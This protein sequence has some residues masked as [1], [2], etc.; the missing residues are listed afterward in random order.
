MRVML[1]GRTRSCAA[2]SPDRLLAVAVERAEHRHL[3]HAQRVGGVTLGREPAAQSHH[4]EPVFRR[5]DRRRCGR[6]LSTVRVMIVSVT[7]YLVLTQGGLLRLRRPAPGPRREVRRPGRDADDAAVPAQRASAPRQRPADPGAAEHRRRLVH[8]GDRRL[9]GRARLDQQHVPQERR[10]VRQPHRGLRPRRAAGRVDRPVRR[11]RRAQG[12]PGRVGRRAQRVDPGPDRSTS[13][14]SSPAAASRRTSSAGRRR[15]VRRRA[16]HHRRSACSSTTRPGTPARR[17]SRRAAPAPATGWTDVPTSY[18]PAQEMRLRVLDSGVDKYGLNAYI[19]DS[20]DDG[21]HQL[22]PGAVLADQGR[23]RRRRRPAPGRVGRRQGHDRRRRA[24]RQDRRHA[25]QGREAVPRPVPR[26]A[27]P[28][29]GDPRDRDLADLARRA[30]LH[31][32]FDEYLAAEFPTSTAAD[33]AIL[34]AGV[35][36]E[37]TYVEQGLYWSTGHRPMLEYVAETYQPD[38]LLVGMPTT[39]EFQHQFLG[40]VTQD[41][42]ERRSATRP[43]TT[44][45]ST[46]CATAASTERERL[47][48]RGVPGGRRDAARW[49]AR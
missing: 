47:H 42:A 38:L 9:A 31:R 17:R 2:S 48:P 30:G 27:V 39:D 5:R 43:T 35:V 1:G 8:A 4:R 25:G 33:F 24:R 7:H 45:T 32:D 34:E 19:Y 23:R 10:P 36:S 46:A 29:L 20:T 21:T 26:A 16:V 22:R 14:R 49:P 11:A 12:R 18:S 13:R 6:A 41:A 40:L 3:A 44:S 15:A 37:E 28:H